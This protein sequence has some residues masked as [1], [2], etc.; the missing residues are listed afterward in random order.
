MSRRRET[1]VDVFINLIFLFFMKTKK[2]FSAWVLDVF[3][4]VMVTLFPMLC[5]KKY[6]KKSNKNAKKFLPGAKKELQAI[7]KLEFSAEALAERVWSKETRIELLKKHNRALIND[8][9]SAEELEALYG[10][11]ATVIDITKA[12]RVYT[13]SRQ[14]LLKMLHDESYGL[15]MLQVVRNFPAVVSQ[16]EAWEILGVKK[17]EPYKGTSW[18][19]A[20]VL[21]EKEPK[22]WAVPFMMEVHK[23]APRQRNEEA[24]S[25]WEQAFSEAYSLKLDLSQLIVVMSV[26]NKEQYLRIVRH[27]GRYEDFSPYFKAM[28]SQVVKYLDGTSFDLTT[29]D[30]QTFADDTTDAY[31]RREAFRWLQIGYCLA[32]YCLADNQ[33]ICDVILNNM[34]EIKCRVDEAVYAQLCE[35]ISGVVGDSL[36]RKAFKLLPAEQCYRKNLLA[37]ALMFDRFGYMLEIF[38]PFTGMPEAMVRQAIEKMIAYDRF[39]IERMAELSSDLQTEVFNKME[40]RAQIGTLECHLSEYFADLKAMKRLQ[41]K[42]EMHLFEM[43]DFYRS[44]KIAYI[45]FFKMADEVF[46]QMI[47]SLKVDHLAEL[48]EAYASR[49]GLTEEQYIALLQSR[50]SSTASLVERY[51]GK[52]EAEL[53][54]EE[55]VS[56]PEPIGDEAE[57]KEQ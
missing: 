50:V 39:P 22:A 36:I 12:L 24:L 49:W 28:F 47:K 11:H 48:V 23:I 35:R 41:P 21:I 52:D 19:F 38:Y 15:I 53:A 42:A 17:D 55:K 4:A 3:A 5:V 33:I 7:E 2:N 6:T 32:G 56:E 1:L 27:Y 37:Q 40:T 57:A 25:I 8:V 14:L 54:L 51:V 44:Q 29:S 34:A 43:S 31:W 20:R 46:L 26:L 9:A 18:G 45:Q 13:P 10:E 30:V 16:L